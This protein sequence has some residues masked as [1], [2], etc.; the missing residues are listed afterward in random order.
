MSQSA[1]LTLAKRK[2]IIRVQDVQRSLSCSRAYASLVLHR[3]AKSRA[4]ERVG[5][6]AYTSCSD[7][8]VVAT[9]IITPS[10]LS[11]WSASS[12]LGYTEQMPQIIH[13]AAPVPKAPLSFIGQNI[14][15]I[16]LQQMFGYRKLQTE[17]G[18]IF[19]ATPEKLAID[20]FLRPREMGNFEEIRAVFAGA[21]F[22]LG[23]M[24]DYLTQTNVQS[25]TKRVGYMLEQEKGVDMSAAFHLD[26]NYI[27][28]NPFSRGTKPSRKWRVLI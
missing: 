27:S 1:I 26:R 14:R 28:L 6:N 2:P 7:P 8:L 17:Q 3:A 21:D 11:F 24:K 20:A 25:V 18:S 12:Y 5:R 16:S 9:N 4:L 15:F 19:V 10:Y 23:R 22:S 13:V